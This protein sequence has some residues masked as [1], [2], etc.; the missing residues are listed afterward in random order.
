MMHDYVTS[1]AQGTYMNNHGEIV[2]SVRD[3]LNAAGKQWSLKFEVSPKTVQDEGWLQVFIHSNAERANAAAERQIIADVES[4][5]SEKFGQ[6][7]LLVPVESISA[8]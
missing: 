3:A 5:L 8:A 2:D 4:E 1:A 6:E 7:L